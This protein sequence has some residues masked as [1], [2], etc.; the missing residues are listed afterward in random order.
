MTRGLYKITTQGSEL[1]HISEDYAKSIYI[2]NDELI[3][4]SLPDD[5]IG[6]GPLVAMGL[7]GGNRRVLAKSDVE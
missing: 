4:R 2:V 3:F 5:Y 6:M 1:S 7:D